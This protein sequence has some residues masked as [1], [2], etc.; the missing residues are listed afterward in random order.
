VTARNVDGLVPTVRGRTS[1][2]EAVAGDGTATL[3]GSRLSLTLPAGGAAVFL[4]RE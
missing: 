1:R 3:T 2:L 4:G